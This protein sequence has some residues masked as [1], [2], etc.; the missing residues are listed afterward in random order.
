MAPKYII[1]DFA[2]SE[3]VRGSFGYDPY[4]LYSY[5][6]TI[7]E[8][9]ELFEDVTPLKVHKKLEVYKNAEDVVILSA[10]WS[11]R[12]EESIFWLLNECP[13]AMFFGYRPLVEY[14]R[15]SEFVMHDEYIKI[16]IE[17]LHNYINE[18][19][20][21]LM[22]DCDL[23]TKSG[24]TRR[25]VPL[26]SSYGCG[27][28]CTFC[29]VPPNRKHALNRRVAV[30]LEKYQEMC[31]WAFRN[32]YNVHFCDEDFIGVTGEGLEKLN[33]LR[34]INPRNNKIIFLSTVSS[35]KN[36]LKTLIAASIDPT[37]YMREAGVHLIEVGLESPSLRAAM[38]K[39]GTMDDVMF[40]IKHL[41]KDMV[42]W[43]T[44][45]LFPG[46]NIQTLNDAG[47]WFDEH[48]FTIDELGD[49]LSASTTGGLGQFFQIYCGAR[50]YADA[51]KE[52]IPI[53]DFPPC[54]LSASVVPRSLYY[55]TFVFNPQPLAERRK[56]IAFWA[57]RYNIPQ[58]VVRVFESL[59]NTRTYCVAEFLDFSKTS[60]KDLLILRHSLMYILILA[61]YRVLMAVQQ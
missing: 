18:F 37:K 46:E 6:K 29:P 19:Q 43:L 13:H 31:Q 30:S 48:G 39:T 11:C 16:G 54:R 21:G 4:I 45:S 52:T 53:D 2:T 7:G 57:K 61:R 35:L 5:F 34:Q 12:Q 20:Y 47:E 51:I 14:N 25:V 58:D 50:G 44:M 1:L 42:F 23:H 17:N 15:L 3:V 38:N 9:V 55:D 27:C 36:L 32:D 10:F 8:D 56:E 40:I 22:S 49:R 28:H 24:D 26:F 33:V 60:T 41:P 59:P